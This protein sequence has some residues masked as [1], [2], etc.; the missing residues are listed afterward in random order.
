MLQR[1]NSESI[2]HDPRSCRA[3]RRRRHRSTRLQI[4]RSPSS[5]P[6]RCGCESAFPRPCRRARRLSSSFTVAR[7][8]RPVTTTPRAGRG[9]PGSSGSPSCFPS[10]SAQTMPTCASTGSSPATS[11]VATAR[12][13]RSPPPSPQ[14]WLAT[15]SIQRG[16]SSPVCR[17]VGQWPARCWQPIPTS[18]PAAR[19]S[20]AS[21]S[22]LP[23]ASARPLG[24]WRT[25]SHAHPPS[26]ATGSA[27]QAA[28]P[29]RG[30]GSWSGTAPPTAP[31]PWPTAR[32]SRRSGPTSTA[33]VRRATGAGSARV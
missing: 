5:I 14:R 10:R 13:H 9:L 25:R 26:S 17:R 3:A 18:S 33:G 2:C 31:S 1:N 28:S 21:R 4:S 20:P 29:G 6:A 8:A 24:P 11:A 15:V 32:R 19:S 16:S 27:P 30:R 7:K 12:W 22:A 23:A